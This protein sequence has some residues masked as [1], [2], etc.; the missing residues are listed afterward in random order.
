MVI[1]KDIVKE[2][3]GAFVATLVA[4]GVSPFACDGLYEAFGLSVSLRPVGP[5]KLMFDTELGAGGREGI[6]AIADAAIGED[7][8]DGDAVEGVEADGLLQGSDDAG[9]F[10]VGQDAGVG[11]ARVIIDGD[12]QSFDA[13][14]FVA[15][16]PVAGAAN[17]RPRKASQ[18]LDVH[19]EQFPGMLPLVAHHWRRRGVERTQSVQPVAAQDTRDGCPRHLH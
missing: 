16:G 9:D 1:F 3:G 4:A 5:G 14:A 19:V 6:G 12:V 11:Q 18:L 15:V 7:T 8:L 17:A 10:F 13:G 2:E